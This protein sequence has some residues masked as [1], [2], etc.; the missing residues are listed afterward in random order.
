MNSIKSNSAYAS[1]LAN[2]YDVLCIQEHHLHVY[3]KDNLSRH[4]NNNQYT[5]SCYDQDTCDDLYLHKHGKGGTAICWKPWLNKYIKILP[6]HSTRLTMIEINLPQSAPICVLCSY[7]PTSGAK[8]SSSEYDKNL[9]TIR[10]MI[11]KYRANHTIIWAGD[12]NGSLQRQKQHDKKLQSFIVEK[13]LISPSPNP[14]PTFIHRNEASSSVIDY[15]FSSKDVMQKYTIHEFHHANTS[16]HTHISCEILIPKAISKSQKQAK[17]KTN[18]GFRWDKVDETAYCEAVND[19]MP[20]INVNLTNSAEIEAVSKTLT[21]VLKKASKETVPKKA[22][23]K[24]P[25]R[26]LDPNSAALV[27]E[28]KRAH[29]KWKSNG[30]PAKHHPISIERRQAKRILQRYQRQSDAKRRISYNERVMKLKPSNKTFSILVNR[31]RQNKSKPTDILNVNGS[32]ITDPIEQTEAWGTYCCDLSNPKENPDFNKQTKAHAVLNNAASYLLYNSRESQT[33]ISREE[34][35][36]AIKSLSLNKSYDNN[37]LCAE[38]L[39]FAGPSILP[40]VTKLIN[41]IIEKES[42]PDSFGIAKLTMVGKKD[43]DQTLQTNHRGI[44]NCDI[45]GKLTE[46]ILK[47]NIESCIQSQQSDLQF[48]FT[49]GLSPTLAALILTESINEAREMGTMLIIVLLDAKKAFDVVDHDILFERLSKMNINPKYW[50]LLRSW[51]SKLSSYVSWKSQ[52]SSQF[53]VTQGVRQGGVLSSYLYK[54]YINVLLQQ[55]QSHGLG[56]H[57]GATYV[58]CPSCADDVALLSTSTTEMQAMVNIASSF[59]DDSQTELNANKSSVLIQGTSSQRNKNLYGEQ[60]FIKNV[61]LTVEHCVTHLG[62]N[63]YSIQTTNNLVSDRIQLGRRTAYSLM[64]VGFHGTN[65]LNPKTSM[66]LYKVYVIPRFLY[67]LE[68]VDINAKH[69]EQ[70]SK[71]HLTNIRSL[72]SLPQRTAT[73]AVYLLAG[74]LPI[75]ALIH[76]RMLSLLGTILRSD[77]NTLTDVARRQVLKPSKSRSWFVKTA[78]LLIRYNLP[79]ISM[80]MSNPFSKEKWKRMYK[81]AV[82]KT[83]SQQLKDQ[84]KSMVSLVHINLQELTLNNCH[85]IWNSVHPNS[86]DV[87][88]A[89]IKSKLLTS[90]YLTQDKLYKY[91]LSPTQECQLCQT[92][93]V[94]DTN[95]FIAECSKLEEPRRKYIKNLRNIL[96]RYF[97]QRSSDRLIEDQLVQ[98]TLD[99]SMIIQSERQPGTYSGKSVNQLYREIEPLT[100]QFVHTIHRLRALMTAER[101]GSIVK[102]QP[103]SHRGCRK[104]LRG[105]TRR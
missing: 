93:E 34:I 46:N 39:R 91:N 88:C 3:E 62:I 101:T 45:L 80:L 64:G 35:E 97:C 68:V 87:Y 43:K 69:L 79:N 24:G 90:T 66:H 23:I 22:H 98:V 4:I 13:Q 12:M 53:P 25:R 75:E 10:E 19:C 33:T 72:Q 28:S 27:A 6:S 83:W 41:A 95:H 89:Q 52:D 77:N 94:E 49:A 51:Y 37:Q 16:D 30:R 67:G 60:I 42:V 29:H 105:R 9:D 32:I 20:M 17:K 26:H 15:I 96:E 92:G 1:I 2:K 11:D 74:I 85:A 56:F 47:D 73:P 14:L 57:I 78:L 21:Q 58:G 55:L 8:G 102:T 82:H 40:A 86:M 103:T 31:Q 70:L 7:M 100:R 36:K 61:E 59:N 5:I 44:A 18:T 65:G 54:A 63:R 76:L 48:G 71:F 104:R 50:K 99:I 84:A 38:H 81:Q